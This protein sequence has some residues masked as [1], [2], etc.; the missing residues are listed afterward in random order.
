[1]GKNLIRAQKLRGMTNAALARKLHT[2][3]QQISRW[4]RQPDMLASTVINLCQALEISVAEFLQE[5]SPR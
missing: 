3:P 2:S 5:K 1:M 4:R